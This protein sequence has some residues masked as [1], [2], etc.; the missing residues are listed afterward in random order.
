MHRRSFL[1]MLPGALAVASQAPQP[2]RE[3]LLTRPK[4]PG[5]LSL[6]ARRRSEQPPG[7]GKIMV[8][9][10]VL[11]RAAAVTFPISVDFASRPR[12]FSY[13]GR[14]SGPRLVE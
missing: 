5:T 2:Q 12:D 13:I 14:K 9:E 10:E 6:R 1:A 8:S 7:S 3:S 4:V 11:R